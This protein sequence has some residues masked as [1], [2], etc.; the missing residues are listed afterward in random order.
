MNAARIENTRGD[1]QYYIEGNSPSVS[2]ILEA[3]D[4]E[5]VAVAEACGIRAISARDW[6]EMAY[7]ASGSNLYEAMQNNDGYVGISAPT[8]LRTR[9]ISE[10]V[11]MSLVPI[12]SIGE[13]YGVSMPT[14]RSFI[15]LA[16]TLHQTDYWAEGRTMESLGIAGLKPEQLQEYVSK[17]SLHN[18]R[19]Q[20]GRTLKAKPTT[21]SWPQKCS[22]L[23]RAS[24]NAF[25]LTF[26]RRIL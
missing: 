5:R 3:L 15:H 19:S 1:F 2:R 13:Q 7:D 17:G 25:D 21:G 9:Y 24:N 20:T 22:V 18:D 26:Y 11:P 14:F 23:E 10:D 16:S 6:L 8:N 12:T 4:A